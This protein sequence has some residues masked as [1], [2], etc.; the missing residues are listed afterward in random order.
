[1]SDSKGVVQQL[2]E[3]LPQIGEVTWIGL[4][5]SRHAPVRAVEAVEAVAGTGLAGDRYRT[6]GGKRQVTLINA[7]HLVAVGAFLG[8]GPIDPARVRRNLVVRGL[9]LHALK[10]KRFWVGDALFAHTGACDPCSQMEATLGPGGYNAMRHHGGLTAQVIQGG[11]V[12]I[13]DAVR[14]ARAE[15]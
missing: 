6:Q 11:T 10:G 9:N 7:E 2:M 8:E 5:P 4:R 15:D 13:G 14:V 3:T 1:M 12:R